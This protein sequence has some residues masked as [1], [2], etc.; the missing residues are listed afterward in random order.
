VSLSHVW[1]SALILT[2]VGCAPI[3]AP[4]VLTDVDR[5]RETPALMQ[6]KDLAPAAFAKADKL[7]A[8]AHAAFDAEDLAGSQII[9]EEAL[10]A[11]EEAVAVARVARAQEALVAA[12]A[13]TTETQSKLGKVED[14]LARVEAEVVATERRLEVLRGLEPVSPSGPADPKREKARAA[15]VAS[16]VLEARLLCSAARLLAKARGSETGFVPP[17][18]EMTAGQTALT[19][20][21]EQ[22]K[23]NPSPAPIDQARRSRA[24]CLSALSAVRRAKGATAKTGAGPDA[25]LTAFSTADVGQPRRDDRGV[26]VTLRAFDGDGVDQATKK[27]LA[28]ALVVAAA[29]PTF[30]V[31]VV[32][33]HRD[34]ADRWERRAQAVVKTLR[35]ELGRTRVADPVLAGA[36]A[37]LVDPKGKYAAR[38]DRV[39]VVFVSP[40][41][42]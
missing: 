16:L 32:A 40:R 12:Q 8:E 30:P 20:L 37:P 18:A 15:A 10:A 34:D 21:E 35:D 41:S 4:T 25:L 27:T 3:L 36:A 23:T 2:L 31:M 29:H 24:S 9:A 33:H 19:A 7:R 13:E 26:V 11:Y 14:E 42:L 22:L 39:E 17:T 1:V 6:A 5:V 28:A 38:N